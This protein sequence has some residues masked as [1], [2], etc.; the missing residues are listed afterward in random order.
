MIT[1]VQYTMFANHA[2]AYEITFVSVA[3]MLIP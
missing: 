2:T 1:V 3:W